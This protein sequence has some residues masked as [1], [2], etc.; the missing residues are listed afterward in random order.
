IPGLKHILLL[1]FFAGQFAALTAQL[2]AQAGEFFF[3]WQQFSA[4]CK[5]V[6][7]RNYLGRDFLAG[8]C[9]HTYCSFAFESFVSP[10]FLRRIFATSA[11]TPP[12]ETTLPTI[13]PALAMHAG[14]IGPP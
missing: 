3:L 2:V 8:C 12:L 9:R 13:I 7:P 4:C 10:F 11:A 5:P 1:D 6:G 14:H